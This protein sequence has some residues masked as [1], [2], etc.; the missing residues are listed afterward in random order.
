MEI[1]KQDLNKSWVEGSYTVEMA[2]VFPI[3]LYIILSLI[4]MTFYMHDKVKVQSV[5]DSA[6]IYGSELVKHERTEGGIYVDYENLD[7][8]GIYFSVI[9]NIEHEKNMLHNYV[10]EKLNRGLI[11]GE[12]GDI[13]IDL[14]KKDVEIRIKVYMNIGILRVKEFF[15]G[16]GTNIT[17]VGKGRV[18]YPAEYVRR[19]D[20]MEEVVDNIESYDN[21]IKKLQKQ[22]AKK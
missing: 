8:R 9:G 16:S 6:V 20:A 12:V 18:H 15:I 22:L 5:V 14:S 10:K 4:Y 19:F 7:N 3:V 2:C 11:I 21:L 17:I 13:Y 1:K